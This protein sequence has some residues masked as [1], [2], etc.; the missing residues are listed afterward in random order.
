MYAL[1]IAA[2]SMGIDAGWQPLPEGGLEYIVQIEPEMLANLS[3]ELLEDNISDIPPALA[4]SVRKIRLTFGSGDLPRQELPEAAPAA[5]E[6]PVPAAPA[7]TAL[8][9][10]QAVVAAP[11]ANHADA[12]PELDGAAEAPAGS[13]FREQADTPGQV[14]AVSNRPILGG[15]MT[16]AS[17]AEADALPPGESK[18]W[19]PLVAAA[20]VAGGSFFGMLFFAWIAYDYRGRYRDAMH[21][22]LAAGYRQGGALPA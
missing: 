22:L 16:D 3:P 12:A 4:P 14:P 17:A 1:L 8:P 18:P 19:L 20:L 6:A 13:T 15:S 9:P 2:A 10:G 5:V 7:N 21:K 11:A